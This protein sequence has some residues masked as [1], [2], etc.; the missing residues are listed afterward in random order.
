MVISFKRISRLKNSPTPHEFLSL[1]KYYVNSSKQIGV[2]NLRFHIT[3]KILKKFDR[4]NFR[5][6]FC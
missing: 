4:H 5:G 2:F 3:N 1:D 6:N